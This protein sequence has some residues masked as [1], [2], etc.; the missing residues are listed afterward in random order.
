MNA[1]RALLVNATEIAKA[2]TLSKS[3]AEN[4]TYLFRA[5]MDE[6]KTEIQTL[7]VREAT[8]LRVDAMGLLRALETLQQ[9]MNED[10]QVMRTDVE[11][12]VEMRRSAIRSESKD[13]ELRIQELDNKFTVKLGDL[14]TAMER[15]KWDA[16]RRLLLALVGLAVI[17][18]YIINRP[19]KQPEET[20][21]VPDEG[22][23][24]PGPGNTFISLG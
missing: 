11:M 1:I 7:R 21:F 13:I 22:D 2:E 20:E 4:T 9:K 14:R 10:L 24:R 19:R 23:S 3:D 16:T 18:T 5:A 8:Q 17:G 12:D 15:Y 6:L